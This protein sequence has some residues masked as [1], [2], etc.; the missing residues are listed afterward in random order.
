MQQKQ[1]RKG[2]RDGQEEA[3]GQEEGAELKSSPA[4]F[5]AQ[6]ADD[7]Q[8]YE[9]QYFVDHL[10]SP[11]GVQAS[12]SVALTNM[13]GAQ[14]VP[15]DTK[16]IFGNAFEFPEGETAT[17]GTAA[18]AFMTFKN[19]DLCEHASSNGGKE[20]RQVAMCTLW[21][22]RARS[23]AL[24]QRVTSV[25]GQALEEEAAEKTR[26]Q[27][28]PQ[29][30]TSSRDFCVPAFAREDAP[31]WSRR[32][33]RRPGHERTTWLGFFGRSAKSRESGYMACV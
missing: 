25:R 31:A 26:Q 16:V 14:A 18:E 28:P 15:K 19:T 4:F 27:Y 13:K 29:Q 21:G 1:D 8:D 6:G 33:D 17:G 10:E 12:N 30:G 23:R 32:L 9:E 3:P 20:R 22:S 11:D 7:V 24:F 2:Q 5:V